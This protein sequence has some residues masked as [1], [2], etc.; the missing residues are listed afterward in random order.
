MVTGQRHLSMLAYTQLSTLCDVTFRLNLP[1]FTVSWE[2]SQW[3]KYLSQ[4][5]LRASMSGARLNTN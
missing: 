4:V 1:P 5:C 2:G 3:N